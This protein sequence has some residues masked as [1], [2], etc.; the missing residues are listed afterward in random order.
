MRLASCLHD[1]AAH[2]TAHARNKLENVQMSRPHRLGFCVWSLLCIV[3]AGFETP[4]KHSLQ[5]RFTLH[6]GNALAPR[7]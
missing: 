4:R 7:A 5:L 1:T 6:Y 2:R 3:C